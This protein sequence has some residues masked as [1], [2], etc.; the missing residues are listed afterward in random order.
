MANFPFQRLQADL[1]VLIL[2]TPAGQRLISEPQLA[3]Q[4]GVSRATLREAMRTFE[5]QGLIRRRQ[6]AGTFV[7]GKVPVIEAGL[8]VL[9]SLETMAQR[10]DLKIT[11]SDLHGEQVEADEKAAEALGILEG[12]RLTRIRRVI[13]ADSR[14]VAYLID[15]LS[16]EILMPDALP[17]QFNG[18]VLDYLLSSRVDLKLSRAAI[19]ATNAPAD[20]AK[21]LEIQR[22]DVLLQFTSQLYDAA[23]SV[24]DYS[25]SYFIPGYF[26]FHVNRRVGSP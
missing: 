8:E 24:V 23:G 16:E 3:K 5:T 9:E 2:S 14:P 10:M 7:V 20:V 1:S 6:G 18:S 22:D 21:A 4:M 12:T 19:S 15:I 13:R 11:V 26:H 17:A 25:I